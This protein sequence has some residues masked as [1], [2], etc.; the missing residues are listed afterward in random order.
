MDLINKLNLEVFLTYA[1]VCLAASI[2]L[3][4]KE[5]DKFLDKSDSHLSYHGGEL[6][7]KQL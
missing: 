5:K 1:F 7:Q 4:K 3:K 2:N 6:P